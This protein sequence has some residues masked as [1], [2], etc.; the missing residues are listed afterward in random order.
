MT[1]RCRLPGPSPVRATRTVVELQLG[2]DVPMTTELVRVGDDVH[3]I[4]RSLAGIVGEEIRV[5]HDDYVRLAHADLVIGADRWIHTDLS[6]PDERR[7]H[8]QHPTG[9][10]EFADVA[11]L[12]V[13][14]RFGPFA[15]VAVGHPEAGVTVVD[16]GHDRR[17][18]VRTEPATDVTVI[19]R[20]DPAT[21]VALGDLPALVAVR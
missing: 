10:T 3:G 9:I 2:A 5:G 21:V 15:V 7:Y 18:R 16:L 8:D 17:L 11:D 1:G 4:T 13:G 14:D 6:R 19:R 12:R 20:P